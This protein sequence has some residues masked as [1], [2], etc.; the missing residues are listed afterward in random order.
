MWFYVALYDFLICNREI[1]FFFFC[2]RKYNGRFSSPQRKKTQ[3][4]NWASSLLEQIQCRE[5]DILSPPKKIHNMEIVSF[6]K[7]FTGRFSILQKKQ[8]LYQSPNSLILEQEYSCL[9]N[10][11]FQTWTKPWPIAYCQ[12][13]SSQI[14]WTKIVWSYFQHFIFKSI[15]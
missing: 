11:K 10:W 3:W 4:E 12:F 8:Y 6:Y 14:L 15:T 7:K 9:S 5:K 2:W 1:L 13:W